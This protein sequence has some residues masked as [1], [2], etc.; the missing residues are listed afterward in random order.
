MTFKDSDISNTVKKQ[1]KKFTKTM[2]RFLE[3]KFPNYIFYYV[4]GDSF[5]KVWNLFFFFLFF[6]KQ[7]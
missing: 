4:A 6:K 2:A 1:H 7:I 5:D 3:Y